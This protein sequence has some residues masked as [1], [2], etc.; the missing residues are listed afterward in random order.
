MTRIVALSLSLL[1]LGGGAPFAGAGSVDQRLQELLWDF[2]LIPLD[3][4]TAPPFTLQSLD[5]R[6]VSLAEFRGRPVLVYFWHST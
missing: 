3:G 1:L 2:E 5:G 4:A 6:T